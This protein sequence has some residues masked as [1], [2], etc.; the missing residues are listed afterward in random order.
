MLAG[1][2]EMALNLDELDNANNLKDG[3]P[4]NTLFT[5]HETAYEDSTHFEPYTPQYKKLK[6]G[7]LV[8]LALRMT[9]KKN[10][11]I[12][13]GRATTVMLHI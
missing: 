10:N 1:I 5:Y 7:K 11:I 8:F 3:K 6:N 2:T 12:T 13:D 4:S 9:C